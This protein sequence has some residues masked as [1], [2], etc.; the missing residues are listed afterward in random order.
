MK[1]GIN[2]PYQKL[3]YP[4]PVDQINPAIAEELHD[5]LH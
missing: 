5:I 2:K 1:G 3:I 4:F